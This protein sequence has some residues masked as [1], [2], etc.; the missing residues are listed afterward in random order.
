[1]S[2]GTKFFFGCAAAAAVLTASGDVTVTADRADCRYKTGETVTFTIAPDTSAPAVPL[3]AELTLDNGKVLAASSVASDQGGKI[4]GKLDAPGVLTLRVSGVLGGK[5]VQILSG[6]A[7]EP[8][9]I[10]PGAE[11]PADFKEFWAA[12]LAKAEKTPLDPQLQKLDKYSNDKYTSYAVSFAVPDG[13]VHGFLCIPNRKGPM[14]ALIGI[15]PSGSGRNVPV[16]NQ[17]GNRKVVLWMGVH[18]YP[19]TLSGAERN[20][21]YKAVNTPKPYNL[22]GN[23]D[24][25]K[26]YYH[27][28][29]TGLSRAVDYLATRPEV[30]PGKI[31]AWGVSQGGGLA[32]MLAALNPKIKGVCACVPALCDHQAYRQGRRPGWPRLVD[33]KD[34]ATAACADYYDV[35]NFCRQIAVPVWIIAGLADD[36][37]PPATIA[38]AFNVIPAPQKTLILEPGMGHSSN[39]PSFGNSLG[40]LRQ[41]LNRLPAG[42]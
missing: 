35:V 23:T 31:G 7:V 11:A 12:E 1:M 27:R 39:R 24:R 33:P 14:P 8:E 41:T 25:E 9:K 32:L 38:A 21:A 40:R 36:T 3:K 6:A 28:V 4:T 2:I 5:R 19:A 29:L 10:A 42:K 17:F 18:D 13:R 22:S 20:R 16:V 34:P 37:C 30:D 15:D 26:Y